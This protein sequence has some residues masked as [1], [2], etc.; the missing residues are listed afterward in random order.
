MISARRAR[1]ADLDK[2]LV[3]GLKA[4]AIYRW[5]PAHSR[6]DVAPSTVTKC[7]V[8]RPSQRVARMCA[9]RQAP[10]APGPIATVLVIKL[11]RPPQPRAHRVWA[12]ACAGTTCGKAGCKPLR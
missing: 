6:A 9:G 3:S 4:G 8:V 1:E 12:P 7:R 5:F 2:V 11:N 10:C